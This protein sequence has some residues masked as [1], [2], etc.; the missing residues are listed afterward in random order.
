MGHVCFSSVF[1]SVVVGT[2]KYGIVGAGNVFSCKF[3]SLEAKIDV[4]P[5]QPS[6]R[7]LRTSLCLSLCIRGGIIPVVAAVLFMG[8]F[9]IK[10]H[11][12]SG[13]HK[14]GRKDAE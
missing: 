10:F 1:A 12:R 3:N 11:R 13:I 2:K 7:V 4:N 8:P 14:A 9:Q 5:G 6:F